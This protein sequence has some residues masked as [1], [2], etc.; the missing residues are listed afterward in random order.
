MQKGPPYGYLPEP[1]KSFLIVTREFEQSA[2]DLF[3]ELGVTVV[4]GQRFL[5][6]FIGDAEGRRAYVKEKVSNWCHCIDKLVTIAV[7][8]PQM[9]YAAV[10]KSLQFEWSYF[11]RVLPECSEAF[12]PLETLMY[13]KLLPAIFGGNVDQKERN[14][15]S[16]PTR[17]GGMG[18]R[19]PTTTASLAYETSRK[20]T[21]VVIDAIR[22]R[23]T[24]NALD[25][26]IQLKNAKIEMQSQQRAEDAKTI[27]EVKSHFDSFHVR[28]IE[29]SINE[30]TS[31][32][33]TVLPVER[34]NF[35]LS[36]VEFRDALAIR[37]RRPLLSTPGLCDGCGEKFTLSHVLS[38]KKGGLIIQR[39]NEIRDALGDLTSLVSK[40]VYREPVVREAD[41]AQHVEALIADLGVRGFWQAQKVA[42][43]DIR[44]TDT[45]ASS[46]VNQPVHTVLSR[47]ETNKKNKYN[48]ACIDR[49]AT[50]TPFITSIDGALG[51]EAKVFIKRLSEM[52]ANKWKRPYSNIF[53]WVKTRLAF[54]I[55]RATNHCVRSSR[56]KWRSLGGEDGAF[57]RAAMQ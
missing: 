50:F 46:Y 6:G 2:K 48:A 3:D 36:P 52:L 40:D 55:L 28:A 54:A 56:T 37:Y 11:Q 31:A 7:S 12:Q 27:E 38:C 26:T 17:L 19:D 15:F 4:N 23:G 42:L 22:A 9:V 21:K 35:D 39:H 57:I 41:D 32:W 1:R 44:V 14:L 10:T 16:L 20:G 45:D 51:H 18:V 33:L 47:A 53:M 43:L 30:K 29:R 24:F 13:D 25:H 34:N 49:R 5:G 8:Q